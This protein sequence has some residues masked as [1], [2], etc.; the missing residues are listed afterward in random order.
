MIQVIGC[1]PEFDLLPLRAVRAVREADTVVL[2][3]AK[4]ACAQGILEENKNALTLDDLYEQ[5]ED[6]DALFQKGVQRIC[7]AQKSGTVAFCVVGDLFDNGF[8]RELVA[9]GADIEYVAGGYAESAALSAAAG[10]MDIGGYAVMGA[11]ELDALGVDTSKTVVLKGVENALVAEH[12]KCVLSDYYT[13]DAQAL[14]YANG[15]PK[16]IKFYDIDRIDAWGEG[17][18]IV[19]PPQPLR[20]KERYGLYDLVRIMQVLRGEN[21]CP[22]DAEQTH[23][24]LRQYI[25]EEAYET[26][27]AV[28]ADDM[29][30]LYDELGDVFLQVVFQSEVGR[31]CGEFDIDDVATSV[32]AKMINRHP[33]IFGDAT[34][35]TAN[36]VFLNWEAIKRQ[37]KQNKDFVSVLR[38]VPRSM[39]AMMRAYK[40]QKKAAGIGFDWKDAKG[41][42]E[43]VRE[44][45]LEWEAEVDAGDTDRMEAEAGDLLFSIINV[46]RL[47]KTNPE[48]ALNRT[49]E[50]FIARMEDM[51][52]TACTG[53]YDLSTDELNNLW[54]E[55]K[56]IIP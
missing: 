17:G 49:C 55:A 16:W 28:D 6:F 15:K 34:A 47:L 50:K 3:S 9:V 30:A 5:A 45:L 56:K 13:E 39:G 36:E 29:F 2:Q 32:C 40:L 41:A 24:S 12:V 1:T 51:E 27:D 42:M 19:L 18:L 54:D 37:E 7:E 44:E 48:V 52:K 10:Q 25:L 20:G 53:L 23:K 46:L 4:A 8:V 33:H 35:D 22:W 26:V 38:D 31:Q 14:L 21:G 43:K 11:R